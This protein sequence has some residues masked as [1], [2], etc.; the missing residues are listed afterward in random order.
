MDGRLWGEASQWRN[1]LPLRGSRFS[2]GERTR[3]GKVMRNN[4]LNLQTGTLLN[5]KELLDIAGAKD[6]V[7]EAADELYSLLSDMAEVRVNE[8]QRL[9]MDAAIIRGHLKTYDQAQQELGYTK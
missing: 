5:A 3:E 6:R 9:L 8:S 2:F 4:F 1:R 7:W